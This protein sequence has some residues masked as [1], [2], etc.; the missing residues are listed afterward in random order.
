M[1][2]RIE[3]A[4]D[5]IKKRF[6]KKLSLTELAA[7]VQ[8]SPFYFQRLFKAELHETPAE[9]LTRVRLENAAHLMVLNP[10]ILMTALS[11]E[12]GFSSLADFSRRFT[13]KY[14]QAPSAYIK[15]IKKKQKGNQTGDVLEVLVEFFPGTRILYSHCSFHDTD[16]NEKF[17]SVALFCKRHKIPI[18]ERRIGVI[19]FIALHKSKEA[20]NYYAG[21]ELKPGLV[22]KFTDKE[23]SINAGR[24]ASFVT[25][26]PSSDTFQILHKFKT[27]WL[28]RSNYII[29]EPFAFEEH[30]V[31]RSTAG[32]P[33]SKR[34][35]YIPVAVKPN[36]GPNKK[37][38]A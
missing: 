31:D 19:S 3:N 35:L 33:I 28:D 9:C 26:K 1:D 12:C 2:A 36:I 24:Y 8:L 7:A 17:N 16:L 27:A 5:I 20:L 23:F 37:S 13:R 22:S 14:N 21:A 25:E 38:K 4:Y 30:L 34:R 6:R 15:D 11:I 18:T 32:K 29:S 10:D